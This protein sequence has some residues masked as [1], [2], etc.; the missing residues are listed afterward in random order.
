MSRLTGYILAVVA[1]ATYGMNPLFAIPLYRQG[2]ETDSVLILRYLLAIVPVGILMLM[3]GEKFSLTLRQGALLAAAGI[4]MGL[5]SWTLFASYRYMNSG[6]ASTLL[7]VYPIMVALIMGLFFR[8]R[9]GMGTWVGLAIA[10]VGIGVLFDNPGGEPLSLLGTVLVGIS[11]LVYAIYMVGVRQTSLGSMSTLKISFYVLVFG[12]WVFLIP[13]MLSGA[14]M[15]LP[16][17]LSGWGCGIGLAVF[18]TAVSFICTALAIQRIGATPTAIL[19]ALEPVTAIIFGVTL[20]GQPIHPRDW[21]GIALILVAVTLTV[22]TT[23]R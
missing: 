22:A 8:E 19:G 16:R 20:L 5:S 23:R 13:M 18:P 2:M 17:N 21:V 3:R 1:A 11:A 4:L 14:G 7:F 12:V 15:S 6:I 10:M 9:L